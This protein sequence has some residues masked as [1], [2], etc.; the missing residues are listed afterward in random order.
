MGSGDWGQTSGPK[1]GAV[2]IPS[3]PPGGGINQGAG[4]GSCGTLV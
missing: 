2:G 1:P 4:S 3:F